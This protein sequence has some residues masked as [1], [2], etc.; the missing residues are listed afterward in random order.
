M[1]QTVSM[2]T[3]LNFPL[4]ESD[5]LSNN[6]YSHILS[7]LSYCLISAGSLESRSGKTQTMLNQSTKQVHSKTMS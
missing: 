4:L 7:D 1:G 3:I 6:L 2:E 5:L